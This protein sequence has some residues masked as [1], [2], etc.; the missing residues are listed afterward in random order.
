MVYLNYNN[1]NEETKERLFKNSKEDVEQQ[2]GDDI[3]SYAENHYLNYNELPER[4]KKIIDLKLPALTIKKQTSY[5]PPA[6]HPWRKQLI[7]SKIQT[8]QSI[9]NN[10]ITGAYS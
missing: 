7:Y 6:N 3:R 8:K 10:Q 2:F 1:P 4:P 9:E 5:K